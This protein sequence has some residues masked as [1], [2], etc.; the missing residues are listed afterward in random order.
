MAQK[1]F[2]ILVEK[3]KRFE[4]H[5]LKGYIETI[6]LAL[7]SDK[8]LLFDCGCVCDAS[9]IAEHIDRQLNIPK[10][11]FRLGVASHAHPDHM[12]GATTLQERHDFKIAAPSHINEW[13]GGL[14]GTIQQWVDIQLAQFVA[15]SNKKTKPKQRLAFQKTIEIDIPLIDG[16][17]LPNFSDWIVF[18][19]PGHTHHDVMLYNREAA[20]LYAGDSIVKIGRD[21]ILPIPMILKRQ[22]WNSFE[23]IKY[24]EVKKLAVAHRGLYDV[25]SFEAIIRQLQELLVQEKELSLLQKTA[26][27][28]QHFSP[29]LRQV[30]KYGL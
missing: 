4:L 7:Y 11:A 15:R 6:Y 9:T 2:A 23:K 22:M 5:T 20:L 10:S 28:I 27:S 29:A 13:Y 26:T 16:Q 21:Y 19:T 1:E 14:S 18:F 3:Y 8:L 30:K 17:Q 12:G 25:E 24:I